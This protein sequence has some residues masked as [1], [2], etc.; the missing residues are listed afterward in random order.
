MSLPQA[1]SMQRLFGAVI[2]L[3]IG[4]ALAGWL[5]GGWFGVWIL[6]FVLP[7]ALMALYVVVG[8]RRRDRDELGDEKFADS[9]YYLGFIFTISAIIICLLD[10]GAIGERL[11]DIAVRFGAAMVTTVAGLIVR[12]ILVSFRKDAHDIR[13]SIEQD[14]LDA[15]RAF[16]TH[17]ELAVDRLREFEGI[18][19][20]GSRSAMA[21]VQLSIEDAVGVY[22]ERFQALFERIAADNRRL[23]EESVTHAKLVSDKLNE[24]LSE[25]ATALVRSMHSLQKAV[26]EFSRNLDGRLKTISFPDDFFSRSL[27]APVLGLRAAIDQIAQQVTELSGT[28]HAGAQRVGLGLDRVGRQA[29][30]ITLSLQQVQA[31]V[32]AS[33]RLSATAAEANDAVGAP[34]RGRAQRS[35]SLGDLG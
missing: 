24:L 18:V 26:D 10:L 28:L 33:G 1:F 35:P 9:C 23:S 7:L 25:H 17:L 2:I 22:S 13:Q 29:D 32:E 19:D 27:A 16:R 21:R 12:V 11:G 31:S 15:E 30:R 20:D 6:G 8:L 14:L 5:V 34:R 3:K 4:S